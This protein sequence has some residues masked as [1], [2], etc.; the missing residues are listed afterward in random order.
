MFNL[1]GQGSKSSVDKEF[2]KITSKIF[3]VIKVATSDNQT[4]DLE[5]KVDDQP[6]FKNIAGD[7]LCFYGIDKGS[8][9]ELIL[10]RQLPDS[11][12]RLINIQKLPLSKSFASAADV[13]GKQV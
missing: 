1:F 8:H 13:S 10:D 11:V 3:P 2:K 6:V 5:L 12:W 9:F 4:T 7:L